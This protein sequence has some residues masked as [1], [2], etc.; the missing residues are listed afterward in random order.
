MSLPDLEKW[1]FLY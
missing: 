1:A